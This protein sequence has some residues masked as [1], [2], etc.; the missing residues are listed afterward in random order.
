FKREWLM[1]NIYT[2]FPAPGDGL[3]E[4]QMSGLLFALF[5]KNS[6]ALCRYVAFSEDVRRYLFSSLDDIQT[7]TGK[8]LEKHRLLA[9]PDMVSACKDFIDSMDLMT[10]EGGEEYLRPDT[11]FN[12]S[13]QRQMQLVQFRALN[14]TAEFPPVPES[15]IAQLCP[16]PNMLLDAQTYSDQL[17]RLWDIHQQE[18][19]IKTKRGY[20]ASLGDEAGDKENLAGVQDGSIPG[21][22]SLLDGL[23]GSVPGNKRHKSESV[24][25]TATASSLAGIAAVAAGGTSISMF[26]GQSGGRDLAASGMIPFEMMSIR[27]VGTSDP[28]RDFEA[29]VKIAT[30]NSQQG[31]RPAGAGWLTVSMAVEQMKRMIVRL[32]TTSFGDQLYEKALDCLKSLRRALSDTQALDVLPLEDDSESA[33]QEKHETIKSRVEMWNAFV[34]ECKTTC[35]NTAVSP[36]R[37]DFWD[38][39]VKQKDEL[40]LLRKGEV[41]AYAGGVSEEEAEQFMVDSMGDTTIA[42]EEEPDAPDEDDLLALM[43]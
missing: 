20:G 37:T 6:Y 7:A 34:K 3:A 9:T 31:V 1:A 19:S 10:A 38:M 17:I 22:N 39:V 41:P 16:L 27:E 18:K 14:P 28:V 33:T 23:L 40:G 15:L 2:V 32:I 36:L 8:K 26:G 24:F 12:P 43:D 29:M 42:Q 13:I 35:L 25:G 4:V 30:I 5:E 21:S 11:T